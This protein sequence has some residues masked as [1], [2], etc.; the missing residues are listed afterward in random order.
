MELLQHGVERVA[1]DDVATERRSVVDEPADAGLGRLDA[2]GRRRREASGRTQVDVDGPAGCGV[3]GVWSADD[4]VVVS[5]KA[6]TVS[7]VT[8]LV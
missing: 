5:G 8:L 3:A 2:P 1:D 4:Y 6:V 7:E